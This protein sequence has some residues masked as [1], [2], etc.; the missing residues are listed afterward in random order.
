M[1]WFL[2]DNGVRLE[3]VKVH[4]WTI[5]SISE[6]LTSSNGVHIVFVNVFINSIFFREF[7]PRFLFYN[8][9]ALHVK[10]RSLGFSW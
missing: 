7:T 5:A 2:Y 9:G 10:F 4:L 1:D 3:K 6:D 8:F